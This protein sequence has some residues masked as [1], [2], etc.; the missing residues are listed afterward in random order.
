MVII[1]NQIL[2]SES[3]FR[4]GITM[5]S[6]AIRYVLMSQMDGMSGEKLG[7][8]KIIETSEGVC[9]SWKILDKDERLQ[10]DL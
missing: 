4:E 1:S 8:K 3:S 10:N 2:V 7:G 5:A 6:I 9:Q